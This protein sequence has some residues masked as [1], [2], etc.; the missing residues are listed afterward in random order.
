MA[1][2][3]ILS[4]DLTEEKASILLGTGSFWEGVDFSQQKEVIQ[5]I[6]RLPFDNPKDYMVQKLN[7]QLR[8]EGK[9]P[10][11]DYSLPV[12]IL[13]LKQAIGRTSRFQDQESLVPLIGSA[14]GDQTIWKTNFRWFCSKCCSL[15]TTVRAAC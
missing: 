1:M 6:T 3:L 4:D 9:N 13:R 12:A 11:K 8:E 5:I 10:F 15:H 7:T 14:S 2:Q